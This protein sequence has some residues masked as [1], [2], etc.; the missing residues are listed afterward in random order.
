[1][2][3]SV[4]IDLLRLVGVVVLVLANAFFVAAEFALVSIRRTRIEELAKQGRPGAAAVK[5]A[6]GHTDDFIAATQLGITIASL[7]LGWL[8]EPALGRFIEPVVALL[9][10]AWV[11]VASPTIAAVLAFIIITFM[12]VV[13][14]EFMPK[15]IA[16][17]RTESTALIVVPVTLVVERI[18]AP[19]IWVLSG[20]GNFLLSLI[21]MRAASGHELVHSVEELKMLVQASGERGVLEV[22]ER[23]MLDAVFDFAALTAR[24]VMVPRTEMV[25]I[26]VEATIEELIQL[27]IKYPFTKYPVYDGDLDH[28]LGIAYVKDLVRVQHSERRTASV[29]G[30]IR[31]ALFVPDTIRLDDLLQHFRARR[32]HMAIVLD[33]YS[34]TAGLVTLADLM[35]K[36]VGEVADTFDKSTPEIQRLPNGAALI[37]GLTQIEDVNNRLGLDLHD[38]YYDTIAGYMLGRL[39][40]MARVGD[41]VEAGRV[42]LKVEA[43]DGLRIA[44]VS[45]YPLQ[46]P[47]QETP[48]KVDGHEAPGV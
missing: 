39:G 46:P 20:T 34:G 38:E 43:L 7:A 45:L 44:R 12:H 28:I 36:I 3:T 32:Q 2:Q 30:L 16:L 26:S 17:Q 42:R 48:A 9:P 6:L 10:A 23:N 1:M 22:D 25:G 27:A 18:F 47:T 19:F 13:V 37:D 8:G 11:G 5:T 40:R 21:G 24:E 41:T 31:E 15:S 29:R 33:E 4:L 14:G 35:G